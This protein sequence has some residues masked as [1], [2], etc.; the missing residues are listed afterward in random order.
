VQQ[1]PKLIYLEIIG[2]GLYIQLALILIVYFIRWTIVLKLAFQLLGV[3]VRLSWVILWAAIQVLYCLYGRQYLHTLVFAL[4]VIFLSTVIIKVLGKNSVLRSFLAAI[5]AEFFCGIGVVIVANPLFSFN[6]NVVPFLFETPLGM[7]VGTIF[8]MFFP[9]IALFVFR[10]FNISP[11]STFAKKPTKQEIFG[12][13]FFGFTFFLIYYSAFIISLTFKNIS[14][15]ALI[16]NLVFEWI[17]EIGMGSAFY[18]FSSSNKKQHEE[19][20]RILE[21]EKSQVQVKYSERLIET[22]ASE[23]REFRNRLQV[24]HLLAESG[25]TEELK[26]YVLATGEDLSKSKTQNIENPVLSSMILSQKILAFERGIDLETFGKVSLIDYPTNHINKMGLV[27]CRIID[28]FVESE[29]LADTSAKT[30]TLTLD[31]DRICCY[32]K[33]KNSDDAVDAF[34]NEKYIKYPR[35]PLPDLEQEALDRF[36]MVE[37]L[38]KELGG[39]MKYNI[40]G[41]QVVEIKLRL[42]KDPDSE[43]PL[44]ED[45]ESE[46][47]NVFFGKKT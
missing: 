34:I 36:R 45:R 22:L 33:F 30:I 29:Q 41:E 24:I 2:K 14:R 16:M 3:K 42:K 12:V 35:K 43:V 7:A 13:L 27:I 21:A 10:A 6:R 46:G 8:E 9:A 31:E 47:Y 44:E 39:T 5:V 15:P 20:R 28:L 32:F 19:E 1:L 11:I 37:E 4:G 17:A 25:K 38:V 40:K 18:A 26:N 23:Q